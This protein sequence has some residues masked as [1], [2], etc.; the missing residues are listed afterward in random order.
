M[1]KIIALSLLLVQVFPSS[2]P[3]IPEPVVL[4]DNTIED[5][6]LDIFGEDANDALAI[7]KCESSLNPRAVNK[8]DKLLNGHESV[9][10]FQISL[11][12]GLDR[13]KLFI[14]DYNI[15]MAKELFDKKGWSPWYNCARKN[16]LSTGTF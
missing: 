2:Q 11:I 12:H 3:V 1:D 6:I 5:K 14:P 15:L 8:G 9:G 10:L 7:A 13:E 16:S 4:V